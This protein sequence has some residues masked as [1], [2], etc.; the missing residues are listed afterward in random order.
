MLIENV[1]RIKILILEILQNTG[2]PPIS[3]VSN[4]GFM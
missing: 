2:R 3:S 1:I 4:Q